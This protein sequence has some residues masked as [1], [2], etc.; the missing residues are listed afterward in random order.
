MV[1]RIRC[2]RA[3]YSNP[4]LST[5]SNSLRK[6]W[7]GTISNHWVRSNSQA[8]CLPNQRGTQ[9]LSSNYRYK[10]IIDEALRLANAPNIPVVVYQ[11]PDLAQ[12][13]LKSNDL[14]WDNELSKGQTHD[15]VEV[16]ANDPL[17]ILYT[18][19]TT[20]RVLG[21]LTK[22]RPKLWQFG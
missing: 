1:C 15:C 14:N 17:Y 6:L 9:K 22:S 12:S 13:E 7:S 21:Q 18:S 10:P 2:Q 11:R 8:Y 3:F 19:G 16:D 5:Q 20:G 4:T